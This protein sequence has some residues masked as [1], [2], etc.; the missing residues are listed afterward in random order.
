M[1]AQANQANEAPEKMIERVRKLL[2]RASHESTPAA[3]ATACMEMATELAAKYGI[4]RAMLAARNPD[5]DPLTEGIFD[6]DPPWSLDQANFLNNLAIAMRCAAV[7][8]HRPEEDGKGHR[9]HI[10][11]FQSDI[12]RATLLFAHAMIQVW[13]AEQKTSVPAAYS[14][15]PSQKRTWK[16][17]FVQ[18]CMQEVIMRVRKIEGLAAAEAEGQTNGTELMLA[19]RASRAQAAMRKA[20]PEIENTAVAWSGAGLREG[21]A[22]GAKFDLGQGHVASGRKG[23]I[24]S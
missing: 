2:E 3:E 22:A 10:L 19:S 4:K 9:L 1:S 7:E 5:A 20:Y 6:L 12:E 16:R 18:G 13:R 14:R 15:T 17:R 11:G 23:A 8:I 24:E 21:R